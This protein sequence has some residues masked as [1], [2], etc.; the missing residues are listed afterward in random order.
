MKNW[1]YSLLI[2]PLLGLASM[3]N[4]PFNY[5]LHLTTIPGKSSKTMICFHGSG[6]NYRIIESLNGHVE[7]TLV[8]FNFPDH[9]FID[10]DPEAV[11]Y[12]TIREL[13]PALY[14]LKLYV[15]DRGLD[16]V[17][18][19]GFSAGGAAAI[20]VIGV[21]NT[22]RYDKKLAEIGI[23]AK[24]KGAILKAIQNGRVILDA[25]FK[26]V[27]EL[28]D[29]RGSSIYLETLARRYRENGLRPI[30]SLKNLEN[31]SLHITLYFEVPDEILSNRDDAL[32]IER[33]KQY[34]AKG[35]TKVIVGTDGGHCSIHSSIWE[36]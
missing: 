11:S 28:I 22:S 27:E 19:Y 17:D 1:L 26:S 2:T 32:F 8:G 4:P 13:L 36:E 29:L 24:E 12:G 21:L 34:N 10:Q 30:D 33:L 14:V 20:N 25:P 31:L 5:D 18:L 6:A 15:I 9:D 7:E 16:Q 35:T 23:F 3:E